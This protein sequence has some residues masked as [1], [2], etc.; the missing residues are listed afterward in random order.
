VTELPEQVALLWLFK[1][2]VYTLGNATTSAIVFASTSS[3]VQTVNFNGKTTGNVT[4]NAAS[5]GSWQYIGGHVTGATATVTLTK[6]TLDIN[7]QTCSWGLFSSSN[8]N[9]RSFTLG[10][11][12]I[13]LTGTG[14]VW[15]FSTIT[16][17]TTSVNSST[18]TLTGSD[19]NF[20][21][22][23][24]K[25]YGSVNLNGAGTSVISS[26]ST[27][28]SLARNGSTAKSDRLDLTGTPT[29]TGTLT[30]AGNSAINRLLVKATT[31]GTRITI[32]NTGATMTWSNVDFQDIGISTAFDASAITGN[33]G[34]CGGNDGITFTTGTTQTWNGTTGGNWSANSWTSHVPLPQDTAD[35]GIAWTASQ[36]V[37]QDMPRVGSMV[38]TGA[39]GS[40]TYTTA[41]TS[42]YGSVTFIT[43][44]T[45]SGN[46]SHTFAGRGTMT[47]T[48]AGK[49]FPGTFVL[50][51]AGGTVSLADALATSGTNS[52]TVTTGILTTNNNTITT[53]IFNSNNTSA[54]RNF[55]FGTSTLNLNSTAATNVWTVDKTNA[56]F[57]ASGLTIVVAS[58]STSTRTINCVQAQSIGAL[59][60]TVAGSTGQLNIVSGNTFGTI[61]F[62]D[63]TNARTLAFTAGTTTTV[64]TFNVN[65]TSGKLMTV[66][67][68]TG[69][70]HTLSSSTNQTCTYLNVSYS[71]AQ[72]G[73]VWRAGSTSTNGG[74]NT[75]WLF[76]DPS[77]SSP[78]SKQLGY[79]TYIRIVN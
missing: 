75:G 38:W 73:G 22:G 39:T 79:R 54:L 12:A 51:C 26:S 45:V 7:G 74:N 42:F 62:S 55:Q 17:L 4:F 27:F 48:S 68:I 71:I 8:T 35:L 16:N 57:D 15:D 63:A 36:T 64:T 20:V 53:G 29:V 34:D 37:T 31:L 21:G 49:S 32:V 61:N 50:N 33:S 11:A 2:M 9:T 65:G 44:M 25:I 1:R 76:T 43:G 41:N 58:A 6:G 19:S 77:T 14:N 56:T 30:L 46:A 47:V 3:V 67:S 18:I 72:G 24:S 23:T 5:N 52:I 60:Y 66:T 78:S 70:T 40:P 69:A 10:A 59:T 13:T 28:G